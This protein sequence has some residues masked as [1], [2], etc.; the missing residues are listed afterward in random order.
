MNN[1]TYENLIIYK[2]YLE[3]NIRLGFG[4]HDA[5]LAIGIIGDNSSVGIIVDSFH[6][7]GD[8]LNYS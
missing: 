2:N 8:S 6:I 7:Y 1:P 4:E 3:Q 5:L